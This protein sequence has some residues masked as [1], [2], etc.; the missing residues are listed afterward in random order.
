MDDVT[1][2][3]YHEIINCVICT[4]D[5]SSHYGNLTFLARATVA[6]LS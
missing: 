2:R 4:Y 1:E 3:N 5:Y 6:S